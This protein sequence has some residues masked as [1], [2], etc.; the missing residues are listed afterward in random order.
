MISGYLLLTGIKFEMYLS[1][2]RFVQS[3]CEEPC[4]SGD[5]NALSFRLSDLIK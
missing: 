4:P 3:L 2:L 1:G 5:N